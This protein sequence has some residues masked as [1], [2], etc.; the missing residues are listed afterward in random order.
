VREGLRETTVAFA[1]QL[2]VRIKNE[3]DK[4]AETLK[5]RGMKEFDMMAQRADWEPVLTKLATRMIGKLY[6]KELFTRVYTV[7]HGKPPAFLK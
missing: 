4:S 3:D 2:K 6:T 1:A 5:K 7:A